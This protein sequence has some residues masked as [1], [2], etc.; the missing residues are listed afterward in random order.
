MPY[1]NEEERIEYAK[2]Y[3]AKRYRE[4]AEY[5]AIILSRA[6]ERKRKY[7]ELYREYVRNSNAKTRT[8]AIILISKG[9]PIC[10]SCG[11]D[12]VKI[13]EI[14][15]KD[16]G[17]CQERKLKW[18]DSNAKFYRAIIKGVRKTDDLNLLCKVCNMLHFVSQ[19]FGLNNYQVT[20]QK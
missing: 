7:P 1:K 4:D 18:G 5:R 19:K 9:D 6:Q 11:C 10:D 14:N 16:G 15:H 12:N 20:W 13:L 3:Y 8:E 2:K 17:G